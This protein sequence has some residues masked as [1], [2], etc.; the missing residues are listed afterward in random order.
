MVADHLLG[1]KCTIWE[2]SEGREVAE[3][4]LRRDGRD[5]HWLDNVAACFA[6]TNDAGIREPTV[7]QPT[8]TAKPKSFRAAMAAAAEKRGGASR[9]AGGYAKFRRGF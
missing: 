3:W 6:I 7:A 8:T 1:E 4:T 2:I 9:P 5:N